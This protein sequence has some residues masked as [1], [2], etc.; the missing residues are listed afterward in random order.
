MTSTSGPVTG[1]GS[2]A[3][4]RSGRA[5]DGRGLP[6]SHGRADRRAR[7]RGPRG[8]RRRGAGLREVPA[9]AHGPEAPAP[10]AGGGPGRADAAEGGAPKFLPGPLLNYAPKMLQ[11]LAGAVL[12]GSLR[13]AMAECMESLS[14]SVWEKAPRDFWDLRQSGNPRVHVGGA[15]VYNRPPI[16]PRLTEAQLR[17]KARLK[18]MGLGGWSD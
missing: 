1:R 9:R 4:S 14:L 6:G 18:G 8:L 12:H 17:E 7:R 13:N 11:K 15:E 3:W 5:T 2:S 10:R 16:V